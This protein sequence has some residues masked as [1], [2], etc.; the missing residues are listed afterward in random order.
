[1]GGN[2]ITPPA[3]PT[4]DA[5]LLAGDFV[6]SS[7]LRTGKVKC[8]NGLTIHVARA[9]E[10]S[11][12]GTFNYL[13]T[14][15]DGKTIDGS[16]TC[17]FPSDNLIEPIYYPSAGAAVKV[18]VFGDA[19]YDITGAVNLPTA[20]GERAEFFATPKSNLKNIKFT[21]LYTCLSAPNVAIALS[22]GGEFR[23]VGAT[24]PYTAFEFFEGICSLQLELLA[25]Y[26]FRVN[27]NGEW[28][29]FVLPTDPAR[30][31]AFKDAQNSPDYK[32][33]S[34]DMAET[35]DGYSINAEIQFGKAICDLIKK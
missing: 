15:S 27:I 32:I 22:I 19:Q 29:P 33:I 25:E 13:I 23:K 6:Y 14:L 21:V 2:S 9:D 30:I 12:T 18:E 26:D 7:V 24:G 4:K 8:S 34:L 1:V 35:T 20:C 11:G 31:Q 5:A 16:I 17:T 3:I 28:H 10:K